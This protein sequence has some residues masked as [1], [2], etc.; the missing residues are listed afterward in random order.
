MGK[1]AFLFTTPIMWYFCIS[2]FPLQGHREKHQKHFLFTQ[3]RIIQYVCFRNH[4]SGS[5]NS[6]Y[7][8]YHCL[9]SN[10]YTTAWGQNKVFNLDASACTVVKQENLR[11]C[12]F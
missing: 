3:E 6:I 2:Y 5:F 11:I 7:F 10:R 1:N 12:F 9:K 4:F 8:K